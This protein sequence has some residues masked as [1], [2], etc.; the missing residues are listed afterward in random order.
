MSTHLSLIG[1]LGWHSKSNRAVVNSYWRLFALT[2]F[3]GTRLCAEEGS[4]NEPTTSYEI[5]WGV[6]IPTRD[7]TKLNG[8]AYLPINKDDG[9]SL[10]EP[11]I[12]LVTP[13][14]SDSYHKVAGYFAQRGY[15][16]LL[17]DCRGRGNSQGRFDPFIN[18][19][20]DCYDTVEWAAQQSFSNGKIGMWG[21]SYSGMNQWLVAAKLPPHLATIAPVAAARPGYDFPFYRSQPIPYNT[22][23]L[24]LV[25]G[26]AVQ[27][28]LFGDYD[29]WTQTFYRAY[30]N[31]VP[32]RQLDAF[33]GNPS[34]IFQK[35]LQHPGL[36]AFWL[37]LTPK[38]EELAKIKIP[39]LSI[40]GQYDGDEY[41]NLSYYWQYLRSGA[42]GA[43]ENCYLVIGPWD[44]AGTR[45]PTA[46]VGGVK[47]GPASLLDVKDL[48]RR[49]WDWI[50]K[51]APKPEFLK[52]HV[53][54]Y[55]LGPGN[56]G[57][58]AWRYAPS[59]ESV[60][61]SHLALFLNSKNGAQTLFSAGS[62]TTTPPP[63]GSDSYVYDPLDLRRGEQVEN[64]PYNEATTNIDQ[65]LASS[66]NGD[67]LI[68]QS[69]PLP[70]E[71]CVTGFP[72]LSLWLSMDVPDTDVE[73]NLYEVLPDGV[74]I[75]IW[76]DVVRARYR[77]SEQVPKLVKAGEVDRYYFDPRFFVARRLA[78]GSRLRLIVAAPNSIYYQ[79]N[80]N[81]GQIV[82]N[83]TKADARIAHVVLHRETEYPSQLS[84][85]LGEVSK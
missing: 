76:S 15:G 73:V 6:Q 83:E 3:C 65:R 18:D 47:F 49:W 8:T 85:P 20:D 43:S 55:L 78:K 27:N 12:V 32:F 56:E 28:D 81:S 42:S 57:K 53:A 63:E 36:D 74:A 9:T 59:L 69:D 72:T 80:Y 11:T 40:T 10:K 7:G 82:A 14:V 35:W 37:N 79:K 48:H 13:Y 61:K 58:G 2:L 52:D 44:H 66:I 50:F 34:P 46:E 21:G 45:N 30:R 62:L 64:I 77:E 19:A 75:N 31:F 60:E 22:Q 41:G 38:T 29:F 33:L 16:F 51:L 68:Y 67:G 39:I 5:R 25:S 71:L 26:V 4:S 24:T 54:Y 23:W 17:V 1:K 70:E 84:I